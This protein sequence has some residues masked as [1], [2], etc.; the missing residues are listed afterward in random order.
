M[1]WK[2]AKDVDNVGIEIGL[3]VDDEDVC[4]RV[5]VYMA[6]VAIRSSLFSVLGKFLHL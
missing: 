5:G 4:V 3:V 6:C 2:V 1:L